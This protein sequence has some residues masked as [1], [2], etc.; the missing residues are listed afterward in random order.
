MSQVDIWW[1]SQMYVRLSHGSR[2]Y[3]AIEERYN[4]QM[5]YFVNIVSLREV[6]GHNRS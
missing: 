6:L 3:F 2:L 4:R 5:V 1:L